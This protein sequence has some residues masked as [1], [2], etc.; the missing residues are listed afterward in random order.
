MKAF[1]GGTTVELEKS[2]VD[3]RLIRD[4]LIEKKVVIL[5][6][7]L[8]DAVEFRKKNKSKKRNVKKIF[9]QVTSA[10]NKSDFVVIEFTIPNFS[11]SHQINYSIMRQKPVLVLRKRKDNTYADSYIEAVESKYLT[12]KKYN[13]KN[14]KQILDD[15]IGF[16]SMRKGYARY[17]VVLED[18]H[19]YYLDWASEMKGESRSEIIRNALEREMKKDV[20]FRKYLK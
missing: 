14:Y 6:D 3:Y 8:D 19:K 5:G 7:W 20:K 1:F 13:L 10:I 15:F 16:N 2:E 17:N 4:Y 9:D 12:L 18:L 11:S